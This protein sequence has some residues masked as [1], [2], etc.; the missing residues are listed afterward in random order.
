MKKTI[1]LSRF[2]YRSR[3]ENYIPYHSS[4]NEI[5]VDGSCCLNICTS[6]QIFDDIPHTTYFESINICNSHINKRVSYNFCSFDRRL[7]S[8][9]K[10]PIVFVP[11]EL[12]SCKLTK[13]HLGFNQGCQTSWF[14]QKSP[15]FRTFSLIKI[16]L[17]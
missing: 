16:L 1:N 6:R 8:S 14:S 17:I 13:F 10:C 2:N 7:K 15:G 12:L 9:W 3:A 11:W 4:S 5:A